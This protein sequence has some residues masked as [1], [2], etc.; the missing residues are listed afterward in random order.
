MVGDPQWL[1]SVDQRLEI[2]EIAAIEGIDRADRQ[3]YAVQR[4]RIIAPE[5]V[6]PVK[7]PAARHH[8]VLRQRLEPAHPSGAGS[9]LLVVFGPKPQAETDLCRS[10]GTTLP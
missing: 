5:G 2:I 6:E 9:D 10:H 3:R 7:R 8:V 4:H 1:D